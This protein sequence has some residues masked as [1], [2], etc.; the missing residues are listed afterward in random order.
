[1]VQIF[2]RQKRNLKMI[3]KLAQ[4]LSLSALARTAAAGYLTLPLKR[5]HPTPVVK[6]DGGP[7]NALVD[8]RIGYLATPSIGNPPQPLGLV[9]DTGSSWVWVN[10]ACVYAR[11]RQLCEAL[12][13]YDGA[14]SR[15]APARVPFLDGYRDYYTGEWALVEGFADTFWWADGVR[16]DAQAFGVANDTDGV[17]T[18]FL[19][20]G[21]DLR[22]GFDGEEARYGVLAGLVKSGLI[23]S[24]AF[25]LG[26]EEMPVLFNDQDAGKISFRTASREGQFEF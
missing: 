15:P 21:P 25:G 10:P 17:A 18:G 19:G 12:A 9:I 2:V 4:L 1:M 24:E 11:N 14:A 7:T 16:V 8:I 3:S 26:L 6:R 13:Q 22:T 5:S 20:L 23:E